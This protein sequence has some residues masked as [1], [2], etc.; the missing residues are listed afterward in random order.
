MTT[1]DGGSCL[2]CKKP[3]EPRGGYDLGYSSAPKS[4]YK[5]NPY[6]DWTDVMYIETGQAFKKRILASFCYC[7]EPE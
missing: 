6:G 4:G 1:G 7:Q 3:N 2:K 5:K